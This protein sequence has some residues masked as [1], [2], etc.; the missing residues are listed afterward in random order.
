[1]ALPHR[2]EQPTQALPDA[3]NADGTMKAVHVSLP[4]ETRADA[5]VSQL[6]KFERLSADW[7]GYGAA[8][9]EKGVSRCRACVY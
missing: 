8:K 4:V 1:M 3:Q 9:P 7:D 5:A 2:I 6:L